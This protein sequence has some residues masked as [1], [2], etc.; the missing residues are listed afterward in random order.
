MIT[1]NDIYEA[2]RKE[3]YAEQLQPLNSKFIQE[4]ADY[5]KEKKEIAEKKEDFFSEE[6]IK[7]KKQFENAV[8]IFRELMLRRKKKILNLGFIAR[9]TGVSKRDCESMLNFEN[10]MFDKIVKSMEEADK[11]ISDLM[12]GKKEESKH[13]LVVFKEK[14]EE[15][16]G[17]DG[18]SIG[19]FEK[20][21][22]ANLLDSIANILIESK[23]VEV[24]EPQ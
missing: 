8:S 19:P 9:E 16:L 2:L 7:T 20:G 21:E 15:F 22:I 4:V 13:I 23:K 24:I 12:V 11:F 1:Y 18:E 6:V 17:F 3:K 10:L 14:V 5:L